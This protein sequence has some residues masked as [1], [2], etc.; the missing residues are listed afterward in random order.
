MSTTTDDSLDD[1]DTPDQSGCEASCPISDD[2]SGRVCD[3][4]CADDDPVYGRGGCGTEDG[5]HGTNCR[6]CFH[7]L[8]TAQERARDGEEVIMCD[9]LAPPDAYVPGRRQ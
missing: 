4:T 1:A 3:P 2:H 9:T 6:E 8:A 5:S 7:D